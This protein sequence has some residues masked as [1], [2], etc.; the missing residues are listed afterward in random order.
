[1][2]LAHILLNLSAI[3]RLR[4]QEILTMLNK[5]AACL[6]GTLSALILLGNPSIGQNYSSV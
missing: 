6:A 2:F 3:C 1:M 4:S 5:P